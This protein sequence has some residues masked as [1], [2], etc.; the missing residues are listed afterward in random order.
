MAASIVTTIPAILIMVFGRRFVVRG[1][2]LESVKRSRAGD[3]HGF[4]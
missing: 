2:T 1:L 4:G 3:D